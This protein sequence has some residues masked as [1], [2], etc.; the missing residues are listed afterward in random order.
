MITRGYF[1]ENVESKT[2]SILFCKDRR[3]KKNETYLAWINSN[4]CLGM[5]RAEF[6][7]YFAI[8]EFL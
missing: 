5:M 8:H 1:N 4:R 2:K 6:I 7:K 3:D